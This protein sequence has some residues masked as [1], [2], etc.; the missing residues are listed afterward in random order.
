MRSF[1]FC[2][3]LYS[4]TLFAYSKEENYIYE[5]A[6]INISFLT[7][8]PVINFIQ[9]K[10]HYN[11]QYL[12]Y[13]NNYNLLYRRWFTVILMFCYEW[14]ISNKELATKHAERKIRSLRPKIIKSDS[15]YGII[16]ESELL[17]KASLQSEDGFDCVQLLSDSVVYP[18]SIGGHLKLSIQL[19]SQSSED[20]LMHLDSIYGKE[21]DSWFETLCLSTESENLGNEKKVV[22]IFNS[23]VL[24]NVCMEL[25]NPDELLQV[26]NSSKYSLNVLSGK[27]LSKFLAINIDNKAT[28]PRQ[29]NICNLQH[30]YFELYNS[31]ETHI[32]SVLQDY[33][34]NLHLIETDDMERLGWMNIFYVI[35]L[36]ASLGVITYI[37]SFFVDYASFYFLA[38]SCA[39]CLNQVQYPGTKACAYHW[40]CTL[41]L[42]R[43]RSEY[44]RNC[45]LCGV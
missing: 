30:R 19:K 25:N 33:I 36:T 32:E 45:P 16:L 3:L 15:T 28:K 8:I 9:L 34:L 22:S 18:V 10:M 5:F 21:G 6:L 29:F 37:T 27:G 4:N 24:A 23:V 12:K 2:L 7:T 44:P 20:S 17:S 31:N 40:F 1:I 43:A 39:I 41:C 11:L 26:E 35:G 38:G 42:K 14:R 13:S